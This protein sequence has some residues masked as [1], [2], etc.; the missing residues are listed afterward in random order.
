MKTQFIEKDS[1]LGRYGL[2]IAEAKYTPQYFLMGENEH[3]IC[4]VINDDRTRL[5]E[6]KKQVE[7]HPEFIRFY[8][9][10]KTPQ[11]L[12]NFAIENN[13]TFEIH[14][15]LFDVCSSYVDFHGNFAEY[16]CAFKYRIYSKKLLSEVKGLIENLPKQIQFERKTQSIIPSLF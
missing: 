6:L 11:E 1:Y 14:G 2:Q 8:G 7:I 4:N 15:E 10:G 12:I 13:L 16:S 9:K 5:D 3:F